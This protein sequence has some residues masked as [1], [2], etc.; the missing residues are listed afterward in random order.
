MIKFWLHKLLGYKVVIKIERGIAKDDA[1]II[2][3]CWLSKSCS[4]HALWE[5]QLLVLNPDKTVS[6][7]TENWNAHWESLEEYTV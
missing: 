6:G 5:G 2:T 4:V 1:P 7:L 3:R